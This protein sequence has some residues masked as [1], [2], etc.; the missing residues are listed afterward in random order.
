MHMSFDIAGS[1]G[2]CHNSH[3]YNP[4]L[5]LQMRYKSLCSPII[6]NQQITT[7]FLSHYC[8][9]TKDTRLSF[10]LTPTPISR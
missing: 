2:P 10:A 3:K 7:C 8:S 1:T 4:H 9:Q 6:A 5:Q